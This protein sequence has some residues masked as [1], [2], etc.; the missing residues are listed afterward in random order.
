MAGSGM[1][2]YSKKNPLWFLFAW[3]PEHTK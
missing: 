2:K 3:F 1:K